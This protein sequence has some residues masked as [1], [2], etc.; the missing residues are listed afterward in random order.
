MPS[1]PGRSVGSAEGVAGI[2]QP[3]SGRRE[4]RQC[5]E[6]GLRI[7]VT[8]RSIRPLSKWVR[9]GRS[10]VQC[11]AIR[12]GS[13]FNQLRLQGSSR[14][15]MR[16]SS[17]SSPG[18]SGDERRIDCALGHADSAGLCEGADSDQQI[19]SEAWVTASRRNSA[20][21]CPRAC[22]N[23]GPHV[24]PLL[25]GSDDELVNLRRR[26]K[27]SVRRSLRSLIRPE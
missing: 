26:L 2:R 27:W 17:A 25:V 14:T 22:R 16:R 5:G 8:P 20:R 18:P 1:S 24:P 6:L 10:L 21:S 9:I 3:N 4:R 23:P 13:G 15:V 12:T 19:R 11:R 7:L